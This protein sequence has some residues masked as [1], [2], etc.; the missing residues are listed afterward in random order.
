MSL[1]FG[2]LFQLGY[3]VAELEAALRTWVSAGVGPWYVFDPLPIQQFSHRSGSTAVPRAKVALAYSG[4]V[5]LELI[6]QLDDAPT[7]Y[8]EFLA[9]GHQG[10]QHVAYL[11]ADYDAAVAAG[12]GQGWELGQQ[13]SAG[14]TRFAYLDA[15]GHPGSVIELVDLDEGTRGLFEHLKAKAAAWDGTGNPVSYP[16]RR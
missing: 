14:G 16:G 11:P 3:V 12:L 5:Q 2:P 8:R 7:M 9:A 1:Y 15:G 6:E 10:L 4:D 13:G